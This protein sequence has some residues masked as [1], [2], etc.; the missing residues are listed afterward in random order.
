MGFTQNK[1]MQYVWC[2]IAIALVCILVLYPFTFTMQLFVD[3]F[4]IRGFYC[5][6]L[7]WFKI[8]CGRAKVDE[9]GKFLIENKNNDIKRVKIKSTKLSQNIGLEILKVIHA[10]EFNFYAQVGV[11]NDAF[12]T[13]MTASGIQ[14]G[15][16]CIYNYLHHKEK[17][18]RGILEVVPN[19]EKEVANISTE[20]K[21]KFSVGMVFVALI[22]AIIKTRRSKYGKRT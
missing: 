11:K 8:L 10:K 20:V 19:F 4:E 1:S 17:G 21:I 13:C 7:G 15:Y 9:N 14:I 12:K 16:G 22:K 5:I 6:K 18:F 3:C 2:F